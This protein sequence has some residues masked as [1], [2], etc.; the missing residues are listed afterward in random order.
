M[1]H[2]EPEEAV[3]A[4]FYMILDELYKLGTVPAIDIRDYANA[5][6]TNVRL[7]T[8]EENLQ[9]ELSEKTSAAEPSAADEKESQEEPAVK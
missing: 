8:D 4:F 3:L 7:K 9:T 6:L 2:S 5:T 1:L